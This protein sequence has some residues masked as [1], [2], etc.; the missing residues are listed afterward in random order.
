[1]LVQLVDFIVNRFERRV[2][3]GALAQQYNAFHYVGIVEHL[4][5]FTPDRPADLAEPDA[6]ALRDGRDIFHAHRNAAGLR[7]DYRTCDV[8]DRAYQAQRAYVDLLQAGLDEAAAGIHIV[9]GELLFY[10]ADT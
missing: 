6:I 7:L 4:A 10:L 8:I 1:M 9:I 2:R 3:I 5:I